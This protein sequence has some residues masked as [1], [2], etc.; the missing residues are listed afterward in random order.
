MIGGDQ[1]H[2][3]AKKDKESFVQLFQNE[4]SVLI[5]LI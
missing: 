5:I 3:I 1:M 4:R 2:A